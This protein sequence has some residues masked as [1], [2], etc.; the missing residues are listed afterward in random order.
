MRVGGSREEQRPE[1]T[2][3]LK[4]VSEIVIALICAGLADKFSRK[5]KSGKNDPLAC[6]RYQ[7]ADAARGNGY[8]PNCDTR[9]TRT[10]PV[11]RSLPNPAC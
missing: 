3:Q 2:T 11:R 4:S 1:A 10:A 6:C 9:G 5:E 8:D 7:N